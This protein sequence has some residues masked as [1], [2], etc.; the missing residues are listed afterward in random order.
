MN[1][2][3]KLR[4]YFIYPQFQLK[5]IAI[6][7][8]ISL[9]APVII[10]AFQSFSFNQQIKNGQMMNLSENH[11]YF[12]FYKEFQSETLFVFAVSVAINFV[13]AFV[14][15]LVVSHRIAGPLVKLK[16][17]LN[18]VSQENE[19]D[20]PVYFRDG[21]FFRDVAEAYNLRFK[22]K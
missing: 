22:K 11:P 12:V 3:R 1:K 16:K 5:L 17:H 19:K 21:D 20:H 15:G 14:I 4:N 13:F 18:H 2:N 9:L 10:F 8:A 7:M 6:I